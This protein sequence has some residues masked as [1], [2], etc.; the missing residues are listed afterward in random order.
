M[1]TTIAAS[2]TFGCHIILKKHI[3]CMDVKIVSHVLTYKN[4][5]T[6][7]YY[8]ASHYAF[9]QV[10]LLTPT[11]ACLLSTQNCLQ[12]GVLQ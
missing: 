12:T 9:Q 3:K 1:N 7:D 10:C 2:Y 11:Q 4:N 5:N 6:D 8:G